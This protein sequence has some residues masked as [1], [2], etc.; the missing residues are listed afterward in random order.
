MPIRDE[1]SW[2]AD[3]ATRNS[4]RVDHLY[5]FERWTSML[6]IIPFV[7]SWRNQFLGKRSGFRWFLPGKILQRSSPMG[8]LIIRFTHVFGGRSFQ[9]WT[10]GPPSPA[11]IHSWKVPG[12]PFP[13]RINYRLYTFVLPT[14]CKLG[15]LHYGTEDKSF[16]WIFKGEMQ[17]VEYLVANAGKYSI[18]IFLWQ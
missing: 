10:N 12:V 5:F 15:L 16:L 7:N 13:E 11:L 17:S 14:Q 6:G 2:S 4:N 3:R 9:E 8:G 1:F 18:E